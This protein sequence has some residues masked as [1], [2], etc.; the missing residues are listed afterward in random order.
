VPFGIVPSCSQSRDWCGVTVSSWR[1][2]VGR[3]SPIAI[4]RAGG[5][6]SPISATMVVHIRTIR[7]TATHA[8]LWRD[9]QHRVPTMTDG[10]T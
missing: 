2:A 9:T 8:R 7:L 4:V 3:G 10:V 6:A 1:T 5:Y